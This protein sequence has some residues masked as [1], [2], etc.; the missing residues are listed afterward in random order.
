M[1]PK[2]VGLI[3]FE[4]VA[5]GELTGPAEAFSRAG[6]PTS[7]EREFRC[8][9]VL[10]LGIG[11]ARCLT[12]CGV[13]VKP[14]LDM[15][16][17]PP[18]DTLV[19]PGGSGMHNVRLSKKIA[20]WLGRRAP[21]TRR[22]AALGDSIYALAATGLLDGRQVA[23]HWRF[24]K[25]VALKFP[26]VRVISNR[27]FVKD[28]PFY[29]CAGGT[30]AVDLSLSLIEEDYGRQIAL[31]LARELIVHVKRPGEQQQYSDALQF[32]VESCGRFADIPSWILCNLNQDLSVEALSRKACMSPR[33]FS[34]LFKA[35]FG[36]TPAEFVA[37]ARVSEARKRLLIPRNSIE[38]VASSLGF[39]SADVFS[40]TF[41]RMVG[42]RPSTYRGSSATVAVNGFV[43]PQ[44]GTPEPSLTHA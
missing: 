22:I 4:Q 2:R 7:D 36:E 39:K 10:T 42:I 5:A 34:R 13:I 8:Y 14:L 19:V 17:A 23:V 26:R 30:S 16:N 3:V 25:D 41:E 29:T 20:K 21:T 37:R 11:T 15:N 40:R 35:A 31:K 38:S 44:L 9:Q 32:Q 43:K 1:G 12:E 24:A 33:N 6:V 27:L 28:G 18:L